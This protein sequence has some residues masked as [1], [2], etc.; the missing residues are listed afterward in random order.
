M[1]SLISSG[2]ASSETIHVIV[3]GDGI[4]SPAASR[5]NNF[6]CVLPLRRDVDNKRL[7]DRSRLAEIPRRSAGSGNATSLVPR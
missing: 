5:P 6:K 2:D 7:G 1:T 4:H 3:C